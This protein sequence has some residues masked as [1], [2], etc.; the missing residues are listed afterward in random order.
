MVRLGRR[1]GPESGVCRSAPGLTEGVRHEASVLS[2]QLR[3][4]AQGP[5][6]ERR[7]GIPARFF[8]TALMVLAVVVVFASLFR[9]G[10]GDCH[11][12]A[13]RRA[14]RLFRRNARLPDHELIRLAAAARAGGSRWDVMASACGIQTDQDLA[15]PGTRPPMTSTVATSFPA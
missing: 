2:R 14:C 7:Q 5:G 11:G 10:R 1:A 12:G 4:G 8:I 9:D 6:S 15:G 3:P 13:A